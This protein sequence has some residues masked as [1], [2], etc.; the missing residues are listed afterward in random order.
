MFC[1]ARGERAFAAASPELLIRRQGLRASTLALAGT[2]RR[3]ADPSVDDHLGE[4]LLRSVKDREEQAIVTR[5]IERTLRPLAVWVAAAEEPVVV[6]MANVQHL[7][8]PIRAQLRA[9]VGAVELAGALHP[10]PAVG[11][12]PLAVGRP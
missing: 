1:V 4:Q 11:G 10:T 3:S 9:P 2:T 12:E 5:R 8:T 7:A 6:R